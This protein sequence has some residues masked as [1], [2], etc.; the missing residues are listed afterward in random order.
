MTLCDT[1]PMVALVNDRDAQH[2]DCVDVLK[3]LPASALLTTWACMTEAMH[4][5]GREAG[6]RGQNAL[7]RLVS[8]GVVKLHRTEPDEWYRMRRLMNDYA[9]A[10]MDLADASLIS[11]AER[12][13]QRRVFTVDQHFRAYRLEGGQALDVVP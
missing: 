13:N 2:T 8:E 6:I 12:L 11:A 4:L 3:A 10:P 1:G 5:L 9:D 7:W